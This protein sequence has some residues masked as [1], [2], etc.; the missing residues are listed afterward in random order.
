MGLDVFKGV[1][2]N[3]HSNDDAS[4]DRSG[5]GDRHGH[6][7]AGRL[8]EAEATYRQLLA[9]FSDEAGHGTGWAWACEAGRLHAAI[10]LIVRAVGINPAVVEFHCNL[11]EVYRLAGHGNGPSPVFAAPL[12]GTGLA[13]AHNNLGIAFFQTGRAGEAIEAHRDDR[14]RARECRGPQSPGQRP[15]DIGTV[16]GGDRRLSQ[17]NH[18]PAWVRRGPE[19]PGQRIHEPG[20]A[21]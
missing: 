13:A 12:N 11:G 20:S 8:A 19:P 9:L 7:E 10:E 3:T 4:H 6:H 16:R 17:G 5:T 18:A 14:T 15:G 1:L 2:S 21:R